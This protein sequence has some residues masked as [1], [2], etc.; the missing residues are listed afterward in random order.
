MSAEQPPEPLLQRLARA[1]MLGGML[2]P[3]IPAICGGV[4]LVA[5]ETGRG[6]TFGFPW[7]QAGFMLGP[8]LWLLFP[9]GVA[10]QTLQKHRPQRSRW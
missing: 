3:G 10:L 9:L 5:I 7:L 4:W 1:C 8:P 2:L 6:P